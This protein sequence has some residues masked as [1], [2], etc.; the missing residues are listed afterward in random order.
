M[1]GT[2]LAWRFAA[3]AAALIL[4]AS[5]LAAQDNAANDSLVRELVRQNAQLK[6]E[7]DA[8]KSRVTQLEARS[9]SPA[10]ASTLVETN[11]TPPASQEAGNSAAALDKT[12]ALTTSDPPL[13]HMDI[14]GGPTLKIRGFFDLNFDSGSAA[15]PLIHPL[16]PLTVPPTPVRSAFQLGEFDLFISSRLSNTLSFV[17]ETVVGSDATNNWGIDVERA[18]LSYKPNDYFELSGG[19]MHTAIGYY[20]TAYHHGTWFQTAAGRPFMYFFED[21]GGI[22]PVHE[23]GISATGRVPHSGS[24]NLHWIAELANGLSS[25]AGANGS[26]PVQNFVSDRNHKAFNFAGFIKPDWAPGLQIG[27]NFYHD[28][29]QPQGLPH[30]DNTI[31]GLYAVYVTPAWE[32]LNEFQVQRDHLEGSNLTY[33]TP[34]GYTQVSRRFGRYRPYFRWQEVNVPSKDPLY[35]SVGRYEAPSPGLRIDFAEFAA[36]KIQFNRLYTRSA[37][38]QNGLDSQVAF[39][40]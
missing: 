20:N 12:S 36:F 27:G 1:P 2:Q 10:Q 31:T 32:F 26:N 16:Y 14:P 38:P 30:V 40:F 5:W 17:S 29:R 9:G 4:S 6:E 35:G 11:S 13:H 23:V 34:L 18:Q 22:L 39:T 15:N 21:S 7:V 33:N 19:R 25:S 37:A 24:L 28:I 3:G 8:L